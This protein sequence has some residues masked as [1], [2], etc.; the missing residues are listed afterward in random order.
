MEKTLIQPSIAALISS[1][2]AIIYYRRKSL[3]LYGA[4]VLFLSMT[5]HFAVGY[6]FGAMLLIFFFTSSKLIE[7]GEEKK[8]R[9]EAGLKDGRP[10][11]WKRVLLNSGVAAVL[12]VAVGC[13]TGWEDKCLDSNE[14]VLVTRLIGGIIGHYACCN[15]DSW[16]SEIGILSSERPWLITT[17]RRVRRGTNGGVTKI[18]HLSASAAGIVVGQ[19]FALIELHTTSC[20]D[21]MGMKELL[22]VPMSMAAGLLGSI[23]R[24]LLGATLQFS[25][26]CLVRKKVVEKPGPTVRR[27][28]GCNYLGNDAVNLISIL[29]TTLITSTACVYIF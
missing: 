29:L 19:T 15:A 10:N 11:S 12:S 27:I 4:L 26:F 9:M 7:D 20:F 13:L 8:R 6:R 24:S 22:I 5:I 18:G 14:S 21:R 3:D 25:G 1:S 2:I 28:S 17:S 23:I 16:S